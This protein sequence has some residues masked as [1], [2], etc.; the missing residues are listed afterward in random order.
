MET[1]LGERAYGAG[2]SRLVSE[3]VDVEKGVEGRKSGEV[4]I[5]GLGVGYC[6][7]MFEAELRDDGI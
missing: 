6:S 7:K 3:L 1:K 2:V 5:D 4:A